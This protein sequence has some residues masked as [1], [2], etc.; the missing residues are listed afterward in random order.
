MVPTHVRRSFEGAGERRAHA[1]EIGPGTHAQYAALA[2]LHYRSASPATIERILVATDDGTG[3]LAGVLVTSRPTL[4]GSWRAAAWPGRF[5]CGSMRERA[6]AINSDLRTISRVI[7][8]PRYRGTGL[9]KRLVTSYLRGAETP[10]TEAV[11]AMGP[12]CPFLE[13]AGMTPHHLPRPARTARLERR[14]AQL[15]LGVD[16]L[17]RAIAPESELAS[18]LRIWARQ[19]AGTRRIAEGPPSEIGRA[20]ACALIAPPVAYAHTKE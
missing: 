9:A 11:A 10:C 12:L 8:D 2:R 6:R 1:I 5:D 20:A 13:R 4:N 7:V 3:E 17:L 15:G 19:S 16:D 14:L 18:A